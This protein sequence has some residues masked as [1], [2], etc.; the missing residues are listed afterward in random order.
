MTSPTRLTRHLRRNITDVERHLWRRLRDRQIKGFKFRRQHP[1]REYVLDFV[2]LE[3]KLV[4][5]LD[6]SQH[7]DA[8]SPDA[9]K[10]SKLV[11]AG[12]QVLR[13]WNN[14]VL[15]NIEGVLEVVWRALPEEIQPPPS[16]PSPLQGEGDEALEEKS[17]IAISQGDSV[18]P[19][20]Y[21]GEDRDRMD[22]GDPLPRKA[23][24][25]RMKSNAGAVAEDR[26]DKK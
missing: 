23:S 8:Q 25:Q 3:A 22:A 26:G 20:P 5:E 10:T 19:S 4:I 12:F 21:K 7:F 24:A 18:T 2:C 17:N 15:S 13:F 14:E 16:L 1:F 11:A 6:D 9:V